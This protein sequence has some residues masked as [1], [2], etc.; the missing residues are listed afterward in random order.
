MSTLTLTHTHTHSLSLSHAQT[1]TYMHIH[2]Y[3]H[4]HT[5]KPRSEA[6]TAREAAESSGEYLRVEEAVHLVLLR[7]GQQGGGLAQCYLQTQRETLYVH[8]YGNCS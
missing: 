4:T 6:Q 7:E 1:Q 2:T 8:T 3:I 5:H